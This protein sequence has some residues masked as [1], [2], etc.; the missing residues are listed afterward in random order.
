[1]SKSKFFIEVKSTNKPIEVYIKGLKSFYGLPVNATVF[2]IPTIKLMNASLY[3]TK[4]DKTFLM[5]CVYS[6]L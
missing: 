6:P 2:I 5:L 1:M 3:S 4:F